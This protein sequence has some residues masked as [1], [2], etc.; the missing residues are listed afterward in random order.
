M[1][2][3][4]KHI[5]TSALMLAL[6]A[7]IGTALVAS[8]FQGTR[9]RIA[10][11]ERRATLRSLNEIIPHSR[12]DNDL[13]EDT[14]SVRDKE[15]GTGES[16]QVYRARRGGEPVAVVLATTAPNGYNGPIKLLVGINYD[17]SLA[18]V[19]V[20]AHRE[21]PGLGDAI[22]ARRSDWVLGFAGKHLGAPPVEAWR[23]RRD[24][25]VFDQFTG[26]TITP[27]AVVRAVKDSLIYFS[28]HKDALFLEPAPKTIETGAADE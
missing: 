19:R 20:L 28:T 21:T 9:A 26:A 23:V 3:E 8:I 7:L 12:Y 14:L 5:L 16:V 10:D 27:R 6:F 1:K 4:I 17:A 2:A 25:G 18:G 13:I 24:G 22:E 15:L 11:N